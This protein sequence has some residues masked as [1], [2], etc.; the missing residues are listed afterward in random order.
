MAL[1]PPCKHILPAML[2]I[3]P[4]SKGNIVSIEGNIY[5]MPRKRAIQFY[6][7]YRTLCIILLSND[8]G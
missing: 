4:E 1:Y 5:S 6:Y 8:R 3:L 7:S 2:T